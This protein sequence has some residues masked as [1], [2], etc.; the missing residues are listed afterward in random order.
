MVTARETLLAEGAR[1][2]RIGLFYDTS[3]LRHNQWRVHVDLTTDYG[4]HWFYATIR[5]FF[6]MI[7]PRHWAMI[8]GRPIVLLYSASFARAHDQS[9]IEYV[10]REFPRQFG[11]RTIIRR[12]RDAHRWSSIGGAAHSMRRAG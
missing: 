8:E 11:G 7:P 6:S 3:T 4:R 12:C 1:P 5:D 2:P 10:K 9:C